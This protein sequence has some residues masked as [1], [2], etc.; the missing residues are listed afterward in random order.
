EIAP[1][2]EAGGD[3]ALRAHRVLSW[4]PALP[5]ALATALAFWPVLNDGF[6]NWDDDANFLE[7]VDFRGFGWAQ[8]RWAWTTDLL[9]VYQPLGWM[10]LELQYVAWGLDPRG[11]HAVGLL[12]HVA[13]ALAVYA[14]LVALLERSGAG[15]GRPDRVGLFAGA[16]MAA[17]LFAVHPLRVE[18]VAW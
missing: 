7:N 3:P 2:P 12:L 13:N 9:E 6:I 14:L 17:A 16:A 10:L 15:L 18:E 4:W 11:Y 5:L 1:R 8:I